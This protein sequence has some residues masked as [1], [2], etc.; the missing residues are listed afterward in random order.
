MPRTPST[1]SRNEVN[2]TVKLAPSQMQFLGSLK[3]PLRV[4]SEQQVLREVLDEFRS[5]FWLPVYQ[6]QLLEQ[7]LARKK[8][9]ILLYLQELLARRFEELRGNA[10]PA[11]SRSTPRPAPRRTVPTE[12]EVATPFAIRIA[13]D[14][15]A[16]ADSLK[17]AL[18][19]SATADVIRE[20]VENVETWC[21]LPRYQGDRLQQDMMSRGLNVL[22]YLQEVLARRYEAIRD[23]APAAERSRKR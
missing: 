19:K 18:E 5:W 1:A 11:T 6:R 9:H 23:E 21:L 13:P 22:E 7:E 4:S 10:P 17:P 8:T 20:L 15:L 16:Y 2:F 14:L 12:P 3:G